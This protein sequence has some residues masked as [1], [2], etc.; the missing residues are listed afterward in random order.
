MADTDRE[1]SKRLRDI[2]IA[3]GLIKV[4]STHW[5]AATDKDKAHKAV[6]NALEPFSEKAERLEA[7][8]RAKINSNKPK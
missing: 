8:Y 3:A 2:K 5:V 6:K 4:S 1:R 7:K